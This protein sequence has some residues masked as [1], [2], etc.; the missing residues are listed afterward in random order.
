[1]FCR[2]GDEIRRRGAAAIVAAAIALASPVAM[3]G[4]AESLPTVEQDPVQAPPPEVEA[5]MSSSERLDR[6]RSLYD[7][8]R[9]KFE[10]FDYIGA[11]ELWTQAY[12]ELP[13]TDEFTGIRAKLMFNIA[14]A[15]L[16]AFE[17]DDNIAHLRQAKRL[18]DLY[19]DSIGE[20]T[21]EEAADARAWQEKISV[22]LVEAEAER[23]RDRKAD[24]PKPPVATRPDPKAARRA[25][26]MTI[27]GAVTLSIG[28]AALGAMGGG[29]VWGASLESRGKGRVDAEPD[30]PADELGK[31]VSQGKTANGLAI[32]MGVASGVL[33]GTGIGLLV[34]GRLAAKKQGPSQ[35]A[36]A[37]VFGRGLVGITARWRF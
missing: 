29:L 36:V 26:A 18:M 37:P 33:I 8:G 19:V 32:G 1:M 13:E 23:K 30:L 21:D 28:I 14:A 25:R 24:K 5:D 3:A 35:R 7:R 34:A 12:T 16:S 17:I 4:P 22:R 2:A 20:A 6:A 15:R 11:I 27:S 31:V 9:G 10:T